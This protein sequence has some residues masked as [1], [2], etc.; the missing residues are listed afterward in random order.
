MILNPAQR[1]AWSR[2]VIAVLAVAAAVA[3]RAWL[4]GSLGTRAPFITFYPAVILAALCGGL[5]AGLLATALS[6]V[7]FGF[8]WMEPVSQFS[9]RDPADWLSLIV[10][11]MSGAAISVV[12]E[13]MQRAEARASAA[14]AEVKVAR[15]RNRAEEQLRRYKLL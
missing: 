9:I 13:A 14:E 4:L 5:P 8:A 12:T 11:A 6:A 2:Y 3:L 15:E 7:V 1:P 10:F